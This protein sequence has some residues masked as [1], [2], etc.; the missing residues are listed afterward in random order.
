M[1]WTEVSHEI[2]VLMLQHASSRVSA[3]PAVSPC[4]WGKLQNPSLLKV[5][6]QAVMLFCV[7][8]VALCDIPTC[9]MTCQKWL[10]VAG[11]ILLPRFQKMRCIFR[12]KRDTLETSHVILHGTKVSCCLS[13]ASRNVR[14]AHLV[15]LTTPHSTLYTPHF[16][17]HTSHSTLYTLHS[18]LSTLHS[19]LRT[20]HFTLHT[21]HL[22]STLY[23]PQLILHTLHFTLFTPHFALCT[24]HFSLHTLHPT[25]YTP[26]SKLFTLPSTL[27]TLYSTL[28][29]VYPT[30]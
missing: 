26:H 3:F 24:P 27:Y 13:F 28:Y 25:L 15:T 11:A 5:S 4:L 6:E 17:L 29:T 23:T 18:T 10:C 2:L 14:A 22:H 12:G 1:K 20:F 9:F 21:L 8:G 30:L 16:T 19:T 7:A